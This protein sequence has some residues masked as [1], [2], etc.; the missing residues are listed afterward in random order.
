MG[1]AAGLVGASVVGGLIKGA[2]QRPS[3]TT[4]KE[5]PG[6][7]GR[8]EA[9]EFG[10]GAIG[11]AQTPFGFTG[12]LRD[13]IAQQR[14]RAPVGDPGFLQNVQGQLTQRLSTPA[15]Q[16]DISPAQQDILNQIFSQRQSTFEN[17][18]IGPSPAAQSAVAAA[19]APALAQ[20]RQQE[21]VNRR[22][23]IG[24]LLQA[25]QLGQGIEFGGRELDLGLVDRILG[26]QRVQLGGSQLQAQTGLGAAQ[27]GRV[28]TGQESVGARPGLDLF[29]GLNV[30][31]NL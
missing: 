29:G 3:R 10:R 7:F 31:V 28:G 30:G 24:Q 27:L 26:A 22:G 21:Q 12:D 25:T 4:V 9:A 17:L 15:P 5:I 19:A 14:G 1:I 11:A 2:T 18:G 13:L 6:V 23:D 20:F 16:G 8:E